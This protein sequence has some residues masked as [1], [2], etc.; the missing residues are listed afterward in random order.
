M[1]EEEAMFVTP[2]ALFRRR[3][4]GCDRETKQGTAQKSVGPDGGIRPGHWRL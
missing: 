3:S 2:A 1:F 4:R